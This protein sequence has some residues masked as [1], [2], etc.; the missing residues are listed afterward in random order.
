MTTRKES[1][2]A[3]FQKK[4]TRFHLPFTR[5]IQIALNEAYRIALKVAKYL[6]KRHFWKNNLFFWSM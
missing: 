4:I 1:P 6:F 2:Q 3:A 5:I